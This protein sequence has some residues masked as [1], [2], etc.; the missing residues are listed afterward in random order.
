MDEAYLVNQ[1]FVNTILHPSDFSAASE[2]AFAHALAIALF[3]KTRFTLLN[4]SSD[5]DDWTKFPGVRDTLEKWGV[6]EEGSS[7]SDVFD[8]LNVQVKKISLQS[9]RPLAAI[10]GYL[11]SHP[12]DLIVLATERREG[13]PRWLK[14]SV[15]EKIAGK[16]KTMT[17][18]VPGTEGG[19]VSLR[20]GSV[21]LNRILVPIDH[22]PDPMPA[23]EY[24]TR[25]A[26]S[27]RKANTQVEV[28]LFHVGDSPEIPYIELPDAPICT[29]KKM[30]KR[31][32]VVDQ[33]ANAAQENA[34][35][36]VIMSTAGQEGILDALRGS[37]TQQVVRRVPC[38]LLAVPSWRY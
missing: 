4:V 3:R 1:P 14:P 9:R 19:F 36:L 34:V 22:D 28:I 12:T 29:W 25:V 15:A 32:N 31:G 20:D 26:A 21:H 17:L 38:P 16:S 5:E 2:N 6:L 37:V 23:V 18:F 24:A 35:G 11:R 30:H 10:L 27:M 13:L 8:K 7:Q 33:I